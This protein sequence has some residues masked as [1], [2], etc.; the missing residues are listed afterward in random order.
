MEQVKMTVLYTGK[1]PVEMPGT[2]LSDKFWDGF[3][4]AVRDRED[5][6]VA[7]VGSDD[8]TIGDAS[9]EYCQSEGAWDVTITNAKDES[10]NGDGTEAH[11]AYPAE[12]GFI[13]EMKGYVTTLVRYC[14]NGF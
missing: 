10:W 9:F 14:E 11:Y 5:V 7:C 13:D 6:T 8:G 2:E 4:R 12:K 3:V 1:A